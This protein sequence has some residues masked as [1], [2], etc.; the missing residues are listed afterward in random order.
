MFI[1]AAA[2]AQ[3]YVY[4]IFLRII[5]YSSK[6]ALGI[7][8]F[9]CLLRMRFCNFSFASEHFFKLFVC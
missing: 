8:R 9:L 6:I 7:A 1:I 5:W 2:H 4:C 3:I